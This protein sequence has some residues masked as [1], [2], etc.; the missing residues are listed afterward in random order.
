MK[1]K[2]FD[3]SWYGKPS[4]KRLEQFEDGAELDIEVE[5]ETDEKE[6]IEQ[7]TSEIIDIVGSELKSLDFLIIAD[8]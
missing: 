3:I 8:K 2:V 6:I 4:A 7:L 1:V 5:D